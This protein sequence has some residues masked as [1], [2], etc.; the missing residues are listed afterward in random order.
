MASLL[1]VEGPIE[2]QNTGIFTLKSLHALEKYTHKSAFLT[3]L[4]IDH[5]NKPQQA[6]Q[7]TE[8]VFASNQT[9]VHEHIHMYIWKVQCYK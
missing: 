8:M 6:Y 9:Y 5:F 4:Q 1:G 3:Y 7:L 2:E